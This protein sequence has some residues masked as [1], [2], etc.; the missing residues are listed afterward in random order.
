[1]NRKQGQELVEIMDDAKEGLKAELSMRRDLNFNP[2]A[3]EN[4]YWSQENLESAISRL[5]EGQEMVQ[6]EMNA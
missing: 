1:M 3:P 6:E 4:D 5:E 2:D